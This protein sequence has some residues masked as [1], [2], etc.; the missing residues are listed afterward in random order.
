LKEF[1]P[2]FSLREIMRAPKILIATLIAMA[3]L[4][5]T[6]IVFFPMVFPEGPPGQL[7]SVRPVPLRSYQMAAL[8]VA[9]FIMALIYPLGYRGNKPWVEGL[10]FG[11]ILG[12][13]S[14]VPHALN[15]FAHA[16]IPGGLLL[17]PVLWTAVTWGFAGL[18]VG[19][20]YGRVER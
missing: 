20:V 5:L 8:L 2:S 19:L 17:T 1:S 16:N 18:A 15:L 12:A 13:L 3:V 11:M 14:G 9:A 6:N 4:S 7:Q 10:R